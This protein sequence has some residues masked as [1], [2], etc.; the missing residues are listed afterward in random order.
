MRLFTLER[1][2][3]ESG[4]S[5]VGTVAEGVQFTNGR[6]V[7]CWK[8]D[9]KSIA[10]Y[11]NLEDI[12]FIHGH[13]GKTEIRFIADEHKEKTK[14]CYPLDGD[15][16]IYQAFGHGGSNPHVG[17]D[18][19][20]RVGTSTHVIRDGKAKQVVWESGVYGCYV[21]VEHDDGYLSLYA[22]LSK[23]LVKTG[24]VVKCGDIIGLS[25]GAVGA[26]GSGKTTGPHLH[27]EVRP[28]GM[29]ENNHN[30]VDPMAY[31]ESYMI[32]DDQQDP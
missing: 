6:C 27:F 3:D 29:V 12:K 1:L 2:E 14:V 25:G 16:P 15:I 17:V 28:P 22:H 26:P 9:V 31:I 8:T 20:I 21:M 7:L 4:V 18:F 13:N 19:A 23:P 30:N 11:D 24:D 32:K 10:I 5:G